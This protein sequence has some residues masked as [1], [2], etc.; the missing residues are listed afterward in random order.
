MKNA[1][2]HTLGDIDWSPE[3]A[4]MNVFNKAEDIDQLVVIWIDKEGKQ[5][6]NASG[7]KN[8]DLLWMLQAEIAGL[9]ERE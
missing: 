6:I 4:L 2:I 1:E 7:I 5:R 9:M 8:R 3:A